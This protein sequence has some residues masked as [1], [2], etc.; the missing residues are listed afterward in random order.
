MSPIALPL[1]RTNPVIIFNPKQVI[2]CD[3]PLSPTWSMAMAITTRTGFM[4]SGSGSGS[5]FNI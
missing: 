1:K 5:N 2:E 4:G 3:G